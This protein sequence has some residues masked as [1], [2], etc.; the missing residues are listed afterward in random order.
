MDDYPFDTSQ[1]PQGTMSTPG[2]QWPMGTRYLV[3]E[4]R[5]CH[6]HQHCGV[7]GTGLV[8]TLS[9][10]KPKPS[11]SLDREGYWWILCPEHYG[12]AD[13]LPDWPNP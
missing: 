1:I 11:S 10:K 13:H 3:T 7:E 12:R 9:D 6:F 8:Y 5:K 2:V 4:V